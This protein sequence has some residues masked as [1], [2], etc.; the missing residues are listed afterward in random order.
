MM[1]LT[2]QQV[3]DATQVLANIINE[4]RPLPTKGKYRVARMH[5]K[6]FP[7]FTTAN[8]QR[9]AKILS[10]DYK[11]VVKTPRDRFDFDAPPA[12]KTKQDPL[13]YGFV[14]T[15]EVAVPDDKMPEFVA[16]WQE[17]AGEEIEVDVTPIPVDQLGDVGLT[18][19]E[20]QTLGDLVAE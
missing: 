11:R 19:V 18:Y 5:A 7:E 13:G 12:P 14:E 1:R 15:E 2:V 4:N 17:I 8:D 6:L 9:T 3:F 20:F 16:W 10:Y